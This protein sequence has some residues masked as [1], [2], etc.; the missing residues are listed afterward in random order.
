MIGMI[1]RLHKLGEAAD[2]DITI[3]GRDA[4]AS[5]ELARAEW[6]GLRAQQ[7]TDWVMA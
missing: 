6:P 7:G 1:A 4:G 2:Q 3:L 5:L